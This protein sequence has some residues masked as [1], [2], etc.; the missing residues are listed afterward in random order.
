MS[1]SKVKSIALGLLVG[2][3]VLASGLQAAF[4]DLTPTQWQVVR[5]K[6]PT[7]FLNCREKPTISSKVISTFDEGTAL[8]L[9]PKVGTF[10]PVVRT[11]SVQGGCFVSKDFVRPLNTSAVKGVIYKGPYLVNATDLNKRTYGSLNAPPIGKRLQKGDK[12]TVVGVVIDKSNQTWV[13][14]ATGEYVVGNPKYLVWDEGTED[15][16]KTCNFLLK[17]CQ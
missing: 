3:G 16:N 6:T 4:A 14:L 2:V 15:P 13:K 17:I 1:G 12:I 9:G 10:F 8:E 11:T 5:L 7:S